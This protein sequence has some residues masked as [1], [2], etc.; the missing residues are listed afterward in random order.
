MPLMTESE[1]RELGRNAASRLAKRAETVL[2]ESLG[3]HVTSFDV[4]LSHSFLDAELVLGVK[5]RLEQFGMKVYVDW[6]ADPLLDRSKVSPATAAALR[7]R[8]RQSTSLFYLHTKN[9]SKSRWM[10][11]ELGYFDA[12]N[13]N[14]AVMP[15][16]E[17][18]GQAFYRGEE[19]LG[20]YPYIDFTGS[21]VYVHR[22]AGLYK[23]YGRWVTESD[24]LR[25]TT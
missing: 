1:A 22:D 7:G 11:W 15:L 10:P 6:I 12:Y 16:V 4:F 17:N 21:S 18:S 3:T 24:K 8:M 25:P 5:T 2:N 19:F 20:L 9:A 13:G 23:Q 14:V